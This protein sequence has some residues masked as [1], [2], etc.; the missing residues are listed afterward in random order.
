MCGEVI[1]AESAVQEVVCVSVWA[2]DCVRCVCGLGRGLCAGDPTDDVNL[3]AG[4]NTV[5]EILDP[6]YVQYQDK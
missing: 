2:R 3:L 5:D 6:I 4:G 1:Y